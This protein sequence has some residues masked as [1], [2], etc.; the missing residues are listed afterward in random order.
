MFSFLLFVSVLSDLDDEPQL[1]FEA[2]SAAKPTEPTQ[3]D[4]PT[5]SP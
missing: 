1:P 4:T 5:P 3:G 2:E